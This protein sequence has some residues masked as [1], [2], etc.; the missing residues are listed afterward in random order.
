MTR[1]SPQALVEDLQDG[2]QDVGKA[3]R[4]T[5]RHLAHDA[6]GWAAEA[7]SHAADLGGRVAA[8]AKARPRTVLAIGAA[9]GA[10]LALLLRRRGR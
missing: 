7:A 1:S 2:A 10:I 5:G 4:R 9:A 8:V 3:L 6:S